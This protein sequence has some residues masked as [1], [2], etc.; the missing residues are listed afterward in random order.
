MSVKSVGLGMSTYLIL[1]LRL[2]T[3]VY[4]HGESASMSSISGL[5]EKRLHSY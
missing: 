1:S 2:E 5:D 3:Q 4:I